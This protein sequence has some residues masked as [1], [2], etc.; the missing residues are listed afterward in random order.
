MGKILTALL[1][2]LL[3]VALITDV[4]AASKAD[5]EAELETCRLLKDAAHQMAEGARG[6]GYTDDHEVIQL[7]KQHWANANER[8]RQLILQLA[9]QP[10]IWDGPVLTK[11]KGVNYGPSG[12]ETYYNLPM[13]GVV[14][15]MRNMGFSEAEY[16]YW[17]RADGCKMLGRYIMAAANLSHWPKGSIVPSSLGDTIICDTGYLEWNQLDIA[18]IWR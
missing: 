3:V 2:A 4:Q 16:P 17:V 12:K 8:E 5:L 15:I 1:A 11:S 10:Y 9:A 18:V 14:R 7:A 6:L 13:G